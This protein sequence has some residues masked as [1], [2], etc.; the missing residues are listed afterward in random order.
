MTFLDFENLRLTPRPNQYL[1]APEGLCRHARPHLLSPVLPLPPAALRE[2][3]LR[4]ITHSPRIELLA[5][6]PAALADEFVARSALFRFP[7]LIS[8][9]VL[10]A[11]AGAS[12]ALYA[13]AVYGYSDLGVNRRRVGRWLAGLAAD[14]ARG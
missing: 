14:V 10:K 5:H 11:G 4:R 12:L 2:L 7:D 13:R 8:V 9:R 1:V 6:D 3:L